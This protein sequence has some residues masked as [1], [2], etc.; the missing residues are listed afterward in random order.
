VADQQSL[1][2]D[3]QLLANES[4]ESEVCRR[5][6]YELQLALYNNLAASY[7]QLKN[8]E[9]TLQ[10]CNR[11]LQLDF[12][13][14][15][16]LYRK[17]QAL[18]MNEVSTLEDFQ[19][20]LGCLDK[21]LKHHPKAPETLDLLKQVH[22][23]FMIFYDFKMKQLGVMNNIDFT[24]I[25]FRIEKQRE[26]L[27]C[28]FQSFANLCMFQEY[29]EFRLQESL[30]A[31]SQTD[32]KE[33]LYTFIVKWGECKDKAPQKNQ[34]QKHRRN[35]KNAKQKRERD[36]QESYGL[37]WRETVLGLMES[38]PLTKINSLLQFLALKFDKKEID[39]FKEIIDEHVLSKQKAN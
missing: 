19:E 38:I 6:V 17:A 36:E 18:V 20:S 35:K 14:M 33:Q 31:I 9:F 32:L 30:K 16:A 37:S 21:S 8:R 2:V 26:R 15:K 29:Q 7:M 12:A 22:S 39:S 10:A 23:K 34:K 11:A 5:F 4:G 1:S 25:E 27:E 3:G 24:G 28:T 13:N